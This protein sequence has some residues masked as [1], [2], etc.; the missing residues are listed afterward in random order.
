MTDP[1]LTRRRALSGAA[2]G[3]LG[4]PLLT[5]CG[6]GAAGEEAGSPHGSPG[7][8]LVATADVPVGG[9]VVL[10]DHD[11]VVTRPDQGTFEG[12]SAACTHQGCLLADVAGGT[13]NCG[14]HGSQFAITD[15]A[16]V[17]GPSGS[18]AGSIPPLPR[19]AVKVKGKNVVWA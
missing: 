12:F 17:A 1:A 2:V 10:P 18:P 3:G 5:A 16:N 8:V 13:I 6:G 14:C 9:G 15:G 4:L 19:V 11:V 7:D